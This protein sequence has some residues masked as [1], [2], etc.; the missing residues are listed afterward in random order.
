MEM[1]VKMEWK[2]E[3]SEG[4]VCIQRN[5]FGSHQLGGDPLR[6]RMIHAHL[7][8]RASSWSLAELVEPVQLWARPSAM[9][10]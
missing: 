5:Q 9:R 4:E 7:C 10:K 8:M 3:Y 1:E 6:H 2:P